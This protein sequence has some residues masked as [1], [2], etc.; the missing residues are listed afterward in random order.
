METKPLV[1]KCDL[2]ATQFDKKVVEK[3]TTTV[4]IIFA[5]NNLHLYKDQGENPNFS[6]NT[7][8]VARLLPWQPITFL[9]Y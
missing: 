4:F 1:T 8:S 2:L 7:R 3:A 9:N 5:L 6:I